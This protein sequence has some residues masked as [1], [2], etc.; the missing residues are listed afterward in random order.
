MCAAISMAFE[1]Q[2]AG[3]GGKGS[4]GFIESF[5]FGSGHTL[6]QT[7][8]GMHLTEQ[9]LLVPFFFIL[10]LCSRPSSCPSPP[11]PPPV[12]PP[13]PLWWASTVPY[14]GV[15]FRKYKKPIK[16]VGLDPEP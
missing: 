7:V 1:G 4:A 8:L 11:L 10:C 16:I 14:I 12:L 5:T 15:G 3:G 9:S 13:S 2:G 6:A